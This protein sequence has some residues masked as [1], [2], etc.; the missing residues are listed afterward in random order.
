M[1]FSFVNEDYWRTR[2]VI[3]AF[4]VLSFALASWIM[5]TTWE[6]NEEHWAMAWDQGWLLGYCEGYCAALDMVPVASTTHT[7]CACETVSIEKK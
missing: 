3:L 2:P 4:V 7:S 1:P 5:S 6:Q